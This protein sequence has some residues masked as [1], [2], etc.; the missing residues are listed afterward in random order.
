MCIAL[1]SYTLA[2][3]RLVPAGCIVLL[4]LLPLRLQASGAGS[5]DGH[6]LEVTPSRCVALHEGQPC[7]QKTKIRWSSPAKGDYCLY[8]EGQDEPLQC[9][10]NARQGEISYVFESSTGT[11][12]YLA[13]RTTGLTLGHAGIVV[14][15]VYDAKSRSK[16]QWRLF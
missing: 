2:N 8:E 12:F 4:A 14:S 7:Y 9:W 11:A 6:H 15:W 1:A 5:N 3:N 13:D 16:T 10:G